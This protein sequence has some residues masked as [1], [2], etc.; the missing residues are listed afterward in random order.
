MQMSELVN[1]HI[2]DDGR[3]ERDVLKDWTPNAMKS[4][5]IYLFEEKRGERQRRITGVWDGWERIDGMKDV[6]YIVR[7]ML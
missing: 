4:A 2:N 5:C 3:I 7:N 1:G 6:D